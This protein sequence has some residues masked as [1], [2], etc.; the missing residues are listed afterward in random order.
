MATRMLQELKSTGIMLG[1][2]SFVNFFQNISQ[3]QKQFRKNKQI[4][5]IVEGLFSK[6]ELDVVK[7]Q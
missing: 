5:F 3:Q 1:I 6:V 7:I 4:N 2:V